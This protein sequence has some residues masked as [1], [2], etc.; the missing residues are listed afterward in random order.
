MKNTL[1]YKIVLLAAVVSLSATLAMAGADAF[2]RAK[3]GGSWVATSGTLSISNKQFVG[4][5]LALGYHKGS[6]V[7]TAGS[8]VVILGGTDVE[9]G[10][11]ALGNIAGGSNAFVKLQSQNGLGTFDSAGFYTGDNNAVYFFN[12]SSPVTSPAV[13]DVFFCGTTATMRISSAGGIQTYTYNYGTTYGS[14]VGLGTYGSVKL[15]N[16]IGFASNCSDG[17]EG[18]VPAYMMPSA[19][20]LSL[21]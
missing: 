6:L 19:T 1:I 11:V 8:V 12:L 17:P 3:L 10:A 14:G 7:N 13:L 18:A 5:S 4:T 15:D 21:K 20:D 9:Y 2:N 16:Y